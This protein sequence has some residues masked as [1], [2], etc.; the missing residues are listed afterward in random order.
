MFLGGWLAGRFG[1][2]HIVGAGLIG[3]SIATLLIPQ[4][5]RLN[6][7]LIIVLR[8]AVGM[9]SVNLFL[10]TFLAVLIAE[11]I[12]IRVHVWHTC[13]D[14]PQLHAGLYF[15]FHPYMDNAQHAV[16]CKLKE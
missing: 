6:Q 16:T 1:G 5:V 3:S 10:I 14:F 9:A 2:K 4:A 15:A 11:I 8:M 13:Y 7:Y 12:W